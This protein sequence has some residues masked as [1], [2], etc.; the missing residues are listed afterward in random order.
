MLGFAKLIDGTFVFGNLKPDGSIE[1]IIKV[2]LNHGTNGSVMIH[3][4]PY[5]P[6][7]P[8][9]LPTMKE[10]RIM[11]AY[12]ITDGEYTDLKD[13]YNNIIS[14]ANQIKSKFLN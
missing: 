10:E 9:F 11:A 6:F 7:N 2:D 4:N 12:A 1:N 13:T 8:A 3:I 5:L 14:G